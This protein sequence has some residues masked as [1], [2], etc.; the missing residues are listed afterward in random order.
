MSEWW[1]NFKLH[2]LGYQY[3]DF[4][5]KKLK[6]LDEKYIPETF[7]DSDFELRYFY[8]LCICVFSWKSL[9]GVSSANKNGHSKN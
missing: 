8:Y 1:Q 9:M 4:S 3:L 7:R 6:N 5:H 2:Y